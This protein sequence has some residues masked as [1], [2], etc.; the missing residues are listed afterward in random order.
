MIRQGHLDI[1]SREFVDRISISPGV[2]SYW[3]RFQR[4][5]EV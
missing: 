3:P 4:G 1:E 5:E 2:N